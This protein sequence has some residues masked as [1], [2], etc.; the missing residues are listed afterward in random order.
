MRRLIRIST[1]RAV[2]AGQ[3]RETRGAALRVYFVLAA[4]QNACNSAL[5][6]L[7]SQD[8]LRCQPTPE[9]TKCP[10]CDGEACPICLRR[11][12][13]AIPINVTCEACGARIKHGG[14]RLILLA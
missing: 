2:A 12:V 13:D 11:C 14:E 7:K 5:L 1:G 9:G 8:S 4:M 3:R 6:D 10:G